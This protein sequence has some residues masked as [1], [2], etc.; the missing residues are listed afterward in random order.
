MGANIWNRIDRPIINKLQ[1]DK[2]IEKEKR[3]FKIMQP[4]ME[5]HI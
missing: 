5:M 4:E 1:N 2:N 3:H